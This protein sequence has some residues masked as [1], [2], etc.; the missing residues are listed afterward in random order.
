[1]RPEFRVGAGARINQAVGDV[2]L[3]DLTSDRLQR[4]YKEWSREGLN[5]RTANAGI[6][7]LKT[8]LTDAVTAKRLN[9]NVAAAVKL[10]PP[11]KTKA[12]SLTPKQLQTLVSG[13]AVGEWGG[14]AEA[15]HLHPIALTAALTGLR[16]GEIVN[17]KWANVNLTDGKLEVVAAKT[18]AGPKLVIA[19]AKRTNQPHVARLPPSCTS[20]AAWFTIRASTPLLPQWR[21]RLRH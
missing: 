7:T 10:S 8:V 2:L 5:I 21:L 1:M 18:D 6:G 9:E 11:A 3:A 15:K 13:L 19:G 4:L 14:S 12:M 20:R 17:L 16:R